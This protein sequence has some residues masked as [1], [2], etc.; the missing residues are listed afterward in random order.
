M[1]VLLWETRFG[2]NY[3]AVVEEQQ[4]I[5]VIQ[6]HVSDAVKWGTG[7]ENVPTILDHLHLLPHLH[8]ELTLLSSIVFSE[9][10]LL[11]HLVIL[12]TIILHQLL[13][14]LLPEIIGDQHLRRRHATTIRLLLA[15]VLAMMIIGIVT[16]TVTQLLLLLT[17]VVVTLLSLPIALLRRQL[18]MLMID[19]AVHLTRGILPQATVLHRQGAQ[20]HRQD[21]VMITLLVTILNTVGDRHLRLAIPLTIL[22]EVLPPLLHQ[23]HGIVGIVQPVLPHAAV[24]TPITLLQVYKMAPSHQ[25]HLVLLPALVVT[26]LHPL[27]LVHATPLQKSTGEAK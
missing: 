4:N 19:T 5:P 1:K 6:V 9:I 18:L 2:S 20:D 22:G 7:L 11:L 17:I 24:V 27:G 3:L 10:I 21:I 23:M 25:H 13:P 14:L 8:V 12:G 15:V 26:F 16:V